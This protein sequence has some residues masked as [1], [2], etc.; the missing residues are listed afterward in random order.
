MEATRSRCKGGKKEN[1]IWRRKLGKIGDVKGS[2]AF[3]IWG[4]VTVKATS[5]TFILVA[6][7]LKG[8]YLG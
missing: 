4:Q 5:G 2:K 7:G 3:D 1:L 6:S 8:M